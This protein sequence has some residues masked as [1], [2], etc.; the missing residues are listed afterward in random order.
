[1]LNH[2]SSQRTNASTT[3]RA[4]GLNNSTGRRPQ[5]LTMTMYPCRGVLH[6]PHRRPGRDGRRT[7]LFGPTGPSNGGVC[8]TPLHGYHKMRVA[9]GPKSVFSPILGGFWASN[10]FLVQFPPGFRPQI[11]FW[12]N[13]RRV[14]GPKS[15][16]GA[17]LA[18]FGAPNRFLVQSSAGLGLQ[19]GFWPN[20]RRVLGPRV[21]VAG[22]E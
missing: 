22:S 7:Y 15:V 16:F 12:C 1:M 21:R 6:T 2:L 8:N 20:P 10:W 14:L 9:A 13:S 18:G 11:G 17:I 4:E 19:I 3:Q 5:H